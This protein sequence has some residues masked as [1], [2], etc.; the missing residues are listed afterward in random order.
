MKTETKIILDQADVVKA[1][2]YW[3]NNEHKMLVKPEMLK[4]DIRD[5]TTGDQ[6]YGESTPAFIRSVTIQEV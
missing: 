3:L 2:V 1:I 6:F 5:S 4:F